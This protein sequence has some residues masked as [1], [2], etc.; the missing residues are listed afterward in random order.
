GHMSMAGAGG[1]IASLADLTIGR[2]IALHINN[3]NPV[4]LDDS[5]ERTEAEA[6]KWIIAEDGLRFTL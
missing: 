6:A 4:L 3:S 2:R 1:S 5:P